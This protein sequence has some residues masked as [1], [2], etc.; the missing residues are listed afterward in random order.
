MVSVH[1]C[2]RCI[3]TPGGKSA[4]F[5]IQYFT[6]A[7]RTT[8]ARIER[9]VEFMFPPTIRRCAVPPHR[10]FQVVR[11]EGGDGRYTEQASNFPRYRTTIT[12]Q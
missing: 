1:S 6:A 8:H 12:V 3:G 5:G 7:D 4:V 11:D 2:A 9:N 10:G